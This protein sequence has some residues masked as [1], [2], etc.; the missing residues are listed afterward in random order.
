MPDRCP[1]VTR[2]ERQWST[3]HWACRKPIASATSRASHA[4]SSGQRPRD[5]AVEAGLAL[6]VV[7]K[8]LV[9]DRGH[10]LSERL[11]PAFWETRSRVG[12]ARPCSRVDDALLALDPD[13]SAVE[14]RNEDSECDLRRFLRGVSACDEIRPVVTFACAT[15]SVGD[16]DVSVH[17]HREFDAPLGSGCRRDALRFGGS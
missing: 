7:S 9:S 11:L 17:G 5:Q 12:C 14:L 8:V 16:G 1:L 2:A 10:C 3:R 6:E 13:R 4:R 15:G